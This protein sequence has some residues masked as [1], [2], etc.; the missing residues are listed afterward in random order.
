MTADD[1]LIVAL[2]FLRE[3][4]KN[5]VLLRRRSELYKVGWNFIMQKVLI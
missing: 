1:R 2:D 3:R 4:S 5:M